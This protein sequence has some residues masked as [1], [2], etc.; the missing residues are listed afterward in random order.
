MKFEEIFEEEG[1]YVANTFRKGV[2]FEIIK[3]LITDNLELYLKTFK[4]K[5]DLMPHSENFTVY[6]GLFKKDY[7]KVYT[8]QS[9]FEKSEPN[10]FRGFEAKSHYCIDCVQEDKCNL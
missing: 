7:R 8:R 3:N 5:D 2:C 6:E 1:L 4:D 9:L 10:C